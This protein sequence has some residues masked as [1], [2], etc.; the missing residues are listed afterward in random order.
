MGKLIS[1]FQMY[2]AEDMTGLV[3]KN[4][5]GY[6]FG[7]EPQKAAK[8]AIMIHQANFGGTLNSYLEN[9]PKETLETDDDF[10]WDLITSGKKNIPLVEAQSNPGTTVVATDKLGENYSV[11]YLVFGEKYF[12]D[13]HLI[14]GERNEAYPIQILDDPQQVGSGWR[15]KCR[16]LTGDPNLFIPYDEVLPGKR[17]SK[18]WAPVEQTM[19]TKGAGISHTFPF[20]MRNALTMIR[21]QDTVP[22]NLKKRP[23]KFMWKDAKTGKIAKTWLDKQAYDFE[24]EYQDAIA[25]LIMYATANKTDAGTYINKGKSGFELQQGAGIKQQMEAS[26]YY[27]YNSFSIKALIDMILDLSVGKIPMGQRNIVLTTGERGM[28]Q[29][30][31]AVEDNALLFTPNQTSDRFKS[32]KGGLSYGGQFL[33]YRGPNG[34]N[35]TLMHDPLKDDLER[36]KIFMP[37]KA[38]KAESYVYDILSMTTS[39]GDANIKK[40]YYDEGRG[41]E[42]GLRNPYDYSKNT[43]MSNP[44]DAWTE[45]RWYIGGA[46][47]YDPTRTAT[48]KPTVL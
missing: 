26:N 40:L 44:K 43:L 38:G 10:E 37:N 21:Y 7:I 12:T 8:A 17:F 4:N 22:G 39:D 18:E 48:Y 14:V 35:I 9:F 33:E 11:F 13:V 23:V 36:N 42:P 46:V 2:E 3:T 1:P 15:Y 30:H 24:M 5:L 27:S 6:R 19:S 20:K 25:K 41:Y 29:F 16:L 47:V 32:I 34:V 45:H 28:V 31:E